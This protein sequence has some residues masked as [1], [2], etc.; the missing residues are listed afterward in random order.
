M[1]EAHHAAV[2]ARHLGTD[3]HEIMLSPRSVIDEF[4]DIL[5]RAPEPIGD[6]SFLPTFLISRETRREV[7][8]ALSGDGGDE[9]FCG[10]EKYKQFLTARRLRS[11]IPSQARTATFSLFGETCGDSVRKKLEALAAPNDESVARWLSTLWKESELGV[12]IQPQVLLRGRVDA[13]SSAWNRRKAFPWIERFMLADMETYLT[14]DILV[15]VDRASM[16]HGLEVRNPLLDQNLIA[17]AF[18]IPNRAR[19]GKILLREMLARRMPR[20]LF[21]RPKHGFGM[22]INE[23]YRGP[24]KPVLEQYTSRSRIKERS[25]LNPGAVQ[26]FVQSHLSGRRNFGRK[27]HAIV[28]FEVWADRF[29]GKANLPC[30]S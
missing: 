20:D 15:K 5:A 25:L 23:W 2:I 28:S 18:E 19:P 11:L 16:A 8:V 14:S 1:N 17:A 26:S 4:T 9:V 3:H 27:L 12:L 6:D 10:Y 30:G 7:T 29:F 22:P 13:F 21:E 24:L